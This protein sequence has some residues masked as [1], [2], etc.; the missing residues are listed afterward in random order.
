MRRSQWASAYL[1]A[2]LTPVGESLLL[3]GD[4]MSSLALIKPNLDSELLTVA[5]VGYAVRRSALTFA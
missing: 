5:K 4:A 2:S 3:V 1:P